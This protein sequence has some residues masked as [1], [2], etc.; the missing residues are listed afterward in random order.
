M[1]LFVTEAI[2]T[3]QQVFS[4]VNTAPL[5]MNR[6]RLSMNESYTQ[7]LLKFI[8]FLFLVTINPVNALENL[9]F[10][11]E[12]IIAKDW[13][14]KNISLSLSKIQDSPQQLSLTINTIELPESF[15]EIKLF[16]IKCSKFTWQDNRIDCLSGV[17]DIKFKKFKHNHF[18]FSFALTEEKS[19]FSF[20]NIKI[21]QGSLSLI[22]K[23]QGDDWSIH[24]KT[25]DL[26]VKQVYAYLSKEYKLLDEIS[27]GRVDA[28]IVLNGDQQGLKRL[29]ITSFFKQLS[30]QA[31]QGE[32][33]LESVDLNWDLQAEL[34]K[35]QWGWKN[36]Q[37]IKKGELYSAP[38]YLEIKEKPLSLSTNG[39]WGEQGNIQLQQAQFIH[40]DVISLTTQ[41]LINNKT[42]FTAKQAHV[43]TKI[44]DLNAF[45]T[46]Y[47][48]P[49]IE[50]TAYQG[51]KLQGKLDAEIDITESAITQVRAK[52][53]SLA[54]NDEENRL[55][56]ENV[57]G[58]INWSNNL[59]FKESS[60][61]FW[62]QI[63]IRAIPIGQNQLHFLFK[64]KQIELL[65]QTSIP[66]LDGSIE[67][68]KF[69]WQN[70]VEDESKVYFEGGIKQLSLDKLSTAL[71][72]T[73]LSGHISG[74]I[75]GVNYEDK[76]L[77][78]NG[79]LQVKLFDGTI[80]INQLT[81]SGMFTEFS[82]LSMEM[83][84]D[85]LDLLEITKKFEMGSMEGRVS[86]YI[87]NLYL[88]NWSPISFYA[89]LG[90]PEA[91]NSTHRISQKAVENIASI[92][93]NAAADIISKGF[94]RFFDSFNY[95]R[96][97]FGCY[98]HQGVCQL[99]GVEAA[100]Q[101]Y[102][103][104]KGGGIPRID[105]I[106]YNTQVDWQVLLERLSRITSTDE[107]VIE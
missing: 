95:D 43:S 87:N 6:Q 20:K 26:Q 10:E 39:L 14:L 77:T 59:A 61:I 62:D 22:I 51:F 21:A 28:E 76:I 16:D 82:K 79:E 9:T 81:S 66:L 67:I 13:Q 2:A 100:E 41:G 55:T 53:K 102:Y 71:D 90:T 27:N 60:V 57:N 72:W 33:V 48:S 1:P 63:K 36:T 46:Q 12:N 101:G 5:N 74:Y 38:V 25:K 84:I 103:L 11:V 32:L 106:G 23:Q 18:A 34:K 88:E 50:Q 73:P 78:V 93:G 42:D 89:W 8:C 40:Q 85:N 98:L 49:F 68:K 56:I 105:V 107:V 92:G 3:F 58:N 17:A 80:K 19:R 29:L 47:I 83:A 7:L 30:L 37:Q 70:S 45:A 54:V 94:L 4:Q 69:N 91:D 15:S 96:L 52:I 75:P 104:I 99:M 44:S 64:Q 31:H 24:I 35:G 65:K 97:G 86:G